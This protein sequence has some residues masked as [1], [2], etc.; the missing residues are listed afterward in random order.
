M[1]IFRCLCT[2][3]ACAQLCMRVPCLIGQCVSG[4]QRHVA[5]VIQIHVHVFFW[6]LIKLL[7]RCSVGVFKC[8]FFSFLF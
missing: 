4:Y 1:Y 8:L 7:M 2:R 5:N 3:V 6:V